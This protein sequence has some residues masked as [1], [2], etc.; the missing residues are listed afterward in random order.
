MD[1]DIQILSNTADVQAVSIKG[2]ERIMAAFHSPGQLEYAVNSRD[3]ETIQ[4]LKSSNHSQTRQMVKVDTPCLLIITTTAEGRHLAISEPT[5]KRKQLR[6]NVAGQ[7]LTIDL[8]QGG[9]GGRSV[10]RMIK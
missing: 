3:P 4:A 10:Y 1:D 2:G 5:Q 8:P 9:Q 7:A 6:L